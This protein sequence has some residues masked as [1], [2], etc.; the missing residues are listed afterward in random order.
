MARVTSMPSWWSCMWDSRMGSHSSDLFGRWLC[1]SLCAVVGAFLMGCQH[2]MTTSPPRTSLVARGTAPP[3]GRA[4]LWAETCMRCLN[5]RPISSYSSA[6][7]PLI[8]HH[9]RVR[10]YLTAEEQRTIQELLQASD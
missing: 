2:A 3:K 1:V 7:W 6:Q 10:G 5:M 8:V 9:M 4:Q